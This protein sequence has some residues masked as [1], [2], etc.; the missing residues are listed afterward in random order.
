MRK[1]KG[2]IF[3]FNGTL[4]LDD[5][6]HFNAWK[7]HTAELGFPLLEE[8]YFNRMHGSTNE[9]IYELFYE[10]PIPKEL[11]GVFG[12][13][14]EVYYREMFKATPPPMAKG[15]KEL[16]D[17]LNKNKIPHAIATSSEIS[18]VTFFNEIYG[19]TSLFGEH[20]TYNDG[21]LRGKPYPD[22]YLRAAEKLGIDPQ[23]LI[24][25]EDSASGAKAC[26]A[27]GSGLVVGICPRGKEKFVGKENTD[28]VITD[29]TELDYKNL[30][31]Y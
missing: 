23:D 14:K 11:I 30:L 27:S 5:E 6:L 15:A 12:N 1:Y 10:K 3:D 16:I 21:T 19:L 2:I 31:A 25:V 20:I 9:L 7:R 13:P 29:F 22:I 18:N 17:F 4:I 8:L 24:M 26:K 28:M